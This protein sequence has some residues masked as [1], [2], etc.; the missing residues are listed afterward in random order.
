MAARAAADVASVSGS[1]A[2]GGL[3]LGFA[4]S[5]LWPSR[6]Q[7]FAYDAG[8]AWLGPGPDARPS[9]SF[10]PSGTT[11]YLGLDPYTNALQERKVYPGTCSF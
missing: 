4:V 1:F 10:P 3:G 6:R 11:V 2:A 7:A 5:A 9:Y 8:G